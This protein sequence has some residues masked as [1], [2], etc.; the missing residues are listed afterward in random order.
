MN[1]NDY[2]HDDW[3][4]Y[5]S[6]DKWAP[7]GFS[8]WISL[9]THRPFSKEVD[10]FVNQTIVVWDGETTTCYIRES[11]RKIFGEKVVKKVV[12]D[13][14]YIDYIC[15]KFRSG[16]DLILSIYNKK[17]KSFKYEEYAGY[18]SYFLNDYYPYHIQVKNVVDFLPK[19][20]SNV[21]L[22]K[23]QAARVHAEPVFSEEVS[24][25]KR[26]ANYIGKKTGYRPEHILFSFTDEVN[27]FWRDGKKLPNKNILKERS[28]SCVIF[29]ENGEI[30]DV[31]V[32]EEISKFGS[33]FL[34]GENRSDIKGQIAFKGRVRGA[35]RVVF[36]PSSVKEF[37]NGDILVAP[38]TR[39]EYL[40][41]MKKAAAFV[42]DGGGILSHAAIIAR[43]M[44]KPCVIGTQIAT[45]VLQDGDL[46]EV[47]ANK[48]VVK[49]INNN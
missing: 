10:S 14:A 4:V 21:Y 40:P 49:K 18:N 37:N 41:I 13:P 8:S 1:L 7:L 17:Q 28:K 46:V 43:E 15:E 35:V 39:P 11:E 12:N 47:D 48:G 5:F 6:G 3:I 16:T 2:K 44:K 24:F 25:T 30:Q 36:D 20:L 34:T 42:T 22:P 19:K 31:L 23:L 38:W 29:F 33:V 32:G 26:I 45:K 27:S 9:Y